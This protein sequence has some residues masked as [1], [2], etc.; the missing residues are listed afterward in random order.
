MTFN[1]SLEIRGVNRTFV[2]RV[3]GTFNPSLEILLR[4]VSLT[5]SLRDPGLSILL[6]RF[7]ALLG[8][9]NVLPL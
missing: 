9:R 4:R 1:P 8:V 6:L 7:P 2:L 3:D 5:A